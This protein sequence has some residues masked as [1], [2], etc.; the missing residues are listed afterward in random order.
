MTAAAQALDAISPSVD[1]STPGAAIAT[2]MLSGVTG[3]ANSIP[4]SASVTV[5]APG[6]ASAAA[7]LFA[8]A[9]AANSI[10]SSVSTTVTTNVVTAYSTI[11][12]PAG[13]TA[14][15]H[16]GIP[17]FAG[18]GL[19]RAGEAGYEQAV[20]PGGLTV[21]LP[22]DGLYATRQAPYVRPA[23]AVQGGGGLTLNV[24]VAG[25]VYGITDLT[26]RIAAE[27]LPALASELQTHTTAIT[28]GLSR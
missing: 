9:N 18:G 16:G 17:A 28:G 19:F 15:R 6:A 25:N 5:S 7:A 22:T 1:V 11:G 4:D 14:V 24:T 12:S 26:E 10:P 27:M 20:Y 8:V 2:T 3:A 13:F 21:G 23:N